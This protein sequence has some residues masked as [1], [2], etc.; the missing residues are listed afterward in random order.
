[1][2]STWVNFVNIVIFVWILASKWNWKQDGT[3][4]FVDVSA[5][6]VTFFKTNWRGR[7]GED[8]TN[9]NFI[10]NYYISNDCCSF[11]FLF[12][13]VVEMMN[14]LTRCLAIILQYYCLLA[15]A[16]PKSLIG[17]HHSPEERSQKP[18]TSKTSP[19]TSSTSIAT[20]SPTRSRKFYF[21]VII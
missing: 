14:F 7:V 4:F 5:T 10:N 16:P 18:F 17:R 11:S 6:F 9:A 12:I 1:M 8:N 20:T 3:Y 13:I 15:M 19:T 2:L 21:A